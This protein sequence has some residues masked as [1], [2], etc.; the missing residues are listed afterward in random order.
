MVALFDDVVTLSDLSLIPLFDDGGDGAYGDKH[1]SDFDDDVGHEDP[2]AP[3]D[4]SPAFISRLALRSLVGQ[5][6]L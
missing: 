5:V 1:L 4:H 2:D 3:L 6:G